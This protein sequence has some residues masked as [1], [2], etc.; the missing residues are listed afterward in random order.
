MFEIEVSTIQ[1]LQFGIAVVLPLFVGLVTTKVTSSN[2]KAVLLVVLSV[3]SGLLTEIAAAVEAGVP[4]DLV[5]GLLAGLT[6][7]VI[8]IAIHYGVWKPTGA[9]NAAQNTLITPK[10]NADGSHTIT[11]LH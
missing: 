1:L 10:P 8:A 2:L 7:L 9:T 6:T 3:A 5:A 4:Y 11:N